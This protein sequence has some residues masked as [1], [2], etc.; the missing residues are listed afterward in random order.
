MAHEDRLIRRH[1]ELDVYKKAFSAAMCL[2][3]VTKSFPNE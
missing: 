2:F 3:E 1:T